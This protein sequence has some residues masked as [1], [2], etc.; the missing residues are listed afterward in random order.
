M[1]APSG[2]PNFL[3]SPPADQIVKIPRRCSDY[4]TG[5]PTVI[6]VGDTSVS[7]NEGKSPSLIFRKSHARHHLRRQPVSP[8]GNDK[9]AAALFELWLGQPGFSAEFDHGL[10]AGP[11]PFDVAGHPLKGTSQEKK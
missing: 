7:L 8:E 11:D 4:N 1:G 5:K 3:K 10:G 6:F 2:G 9:R